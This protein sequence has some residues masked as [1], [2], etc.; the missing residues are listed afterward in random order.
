MRVLNI[1]ASVVARWLI[2]GGQCEEQALRLRDEY[3]ERVIELYG[4]ELLVFEVLNALWKAVKRELGHSETRNIAVR[5]PS[6][7][8]RGEQALIP[9]ITKKL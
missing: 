7:S 5:H 6:N 1:D 9:K 3:A 2:P 4:P 8:L